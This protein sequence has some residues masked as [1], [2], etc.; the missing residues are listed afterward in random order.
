[1]GW[2]MG[3]RK[4]SVAEKTSAKLAKVP[5]MHAMGEP[6]GLYLYVHEGAR[7]WILRYS[8]HG[9]RRDLGLGSY[10]DFTL[11]EARER[12][13]EQRKLVL[14][15]VD[16]IQAKREGHEAARAAA[17]QT[18]SFAKCVDGYLEA[19]ADAWRNAKHRAQWRSS[20][21]TYTGKI[22]GPL[23]VA[24]VDTGLVLR[25][26]DPIWKTKTETASRVRGRIESVLDWATVRGFRRGDNPARWKGHLA[27][28]LANP[29]KV[30]RVTHHPA[31]PYRD[32]GTFMEALRAQQGI[33]ASA[34]EFTIL[35]AARSGET[36]GATWDEIDVAGKVWT[37]PAERMK[38]HR[39]HR[40]PLSDAA[41]AVIEAM[42]AKRLGEFVFP[43]AKEGSPLSD[44]SLTAVI[45]RMKIDNV[46]V[47]GFRSTFRD[48]AAECTNYP[49][50]VAEAALA[51]TKDDKTE[52]AY[53]R[54]DLLAKRARLMGE[55]ARYCAKVQPK[56]EVVPMAK[57]AKR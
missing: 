55:W 51:H 38:A 24:A 32:A 15:K 23:N 53:Q 1:M 57:G 31:L 48:W 47:H 35:T 18:M 30:A 21:D 34:L 27:E 50:E 46:T 41:V 45:R 19:H 2:T 39:E 44:M 11:A 43:G 7:S 22:L 3:L 26:L 17:L 9:R 5:G 40:V 56:G 36:R 12:A 37:V 33:A 8:L 4:M 20:L 49:R 52:A 6:P 25:V 54:G 13:R 16:P 28:L 29:S 10:D 14:A 42:K